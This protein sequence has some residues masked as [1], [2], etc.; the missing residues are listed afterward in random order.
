MPQRIQRRRTRGWR[1][2]E[3]AVYVGRPSRWGNPFVVKPTTYDW[4]VS[5]P[6]GRWAETRIFTMRRPAHEFAVE[7]Y[8]LHTGPMGLYELDADDL[9]HLR[10]ELRARDLCCWCDLS[11]PCHADLLLSIANPPVPAVDRRNPQ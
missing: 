3:G 11:M 4:V 9:L 10:S 6:S 5:D 1:M 8:Q 2:P 7:Q